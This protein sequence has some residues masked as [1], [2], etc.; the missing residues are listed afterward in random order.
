M[1]NNSIIISTLL[2]VTQALGRIVYKPSVYLLCDIL[3]TIL[4]TILHDGSSSLVGVWYQVISYT[5]SAEVKCNFQDEYYINGYYVNKT[6]P[7]VHH[8]TCMDPFY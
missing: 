7:C 2:A 4:T 3:T 5:I 6:K 8:L 1:K